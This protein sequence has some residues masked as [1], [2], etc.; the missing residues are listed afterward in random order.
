MR[1]ATKGF[2]ASLPA[3]VVVAFAADQERQAAFDASPQGRYVAAMEVALALGMET[4]SVSRA[5]I[6]IARQDWLAG[7]ALLAGLAEDAARTSAR[8]VRAGLTAETIA[9]ATGA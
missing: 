8:A 7:R 4:A 5:A 3:E 2:A 1:I 6:D 9:V